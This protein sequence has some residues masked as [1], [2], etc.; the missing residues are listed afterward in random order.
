MPDQTKRAHELM[1]AL[2]NDG[3]DVAERFNLTTTGEVSK[4]ASVLEARQTVEKEKRNGKMHVDL[5]I[6]GLSE[7]REVA[8]RRRK[9]GQLMEEL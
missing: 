7:L 5:N 9:T 2:H 3:Y 6:D 4:A 8:A 1:T